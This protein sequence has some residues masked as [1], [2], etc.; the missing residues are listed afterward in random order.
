MSTRPLSPNQ[1][2]LLRFFFETE[3]D[4]EPAEWLWAWMEFDNRTLSSLENRGL[5]EGYWKDGYGE[6]VYIRVT[7]AGKRALLAKRSP[8]P[9]RRRT[10]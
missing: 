6:P 3:K 4:G 1:L 5:I 10:A 8:L 9:S 2:E 7:P